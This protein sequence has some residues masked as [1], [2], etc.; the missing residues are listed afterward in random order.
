MIARLHLLEISL[1]AGD[2]ARSK[3][4]AA[5]LMSTIV[6]NQRLLR[7]TVAVLSGTS[8]EAA[9]DTQ[10]LL[11]VLLQACDSESARLGEIKDL[12]KTIAK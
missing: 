4:A 6:G 1:K 2:A 10:T 9:L 11:P 7:K 3:Q 8:A 12:L 5:E